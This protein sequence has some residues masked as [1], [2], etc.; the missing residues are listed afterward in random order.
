MPV[1]VPFVL[2]TMDWSVVIVTNI[3]STSWQYSYVISSN[4]DVLYTTEDDKGHTLM[5]FLYKLG[6]RV[7]MYL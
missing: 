5:Y 6:M 2:I 3:I 4:L 7:L 1:L